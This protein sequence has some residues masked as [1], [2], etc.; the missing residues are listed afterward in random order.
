MTLIVQIV[1]GLL[2]LAGLVAIFLS[3]KNW[4]WTQLV[5][6]L[7]IFFSAIGF[8]V[9][10]AETVRIHN[11]LRARIP[12]LERDLDL[13]LREKDQLINGTARS[14]GI[15]Q[16]EHQLQMDSRERG[17]AWRGVVPTG[18]VD[19]QGRVSVEI[20]QPQPHGLDADSIVYAFE[21]GEPNAADPEAG[22]EF[23]G[24][25]R[26]TN[27][28][29]AGVTLEPVQLIDNRTG[30]RLVDS[31]GPWSLYETMPIDRHRLFAD[32][33]EEQL[34]QM[35]PEE[36][37]EEYLRHGQEA[38]PDDDEWHVIGLDENGVRVGPDDLDKAVKRLYNRTLR[39]YAFI[40]SE[41]ANE[42]VAI[43]ARQRAVTQDNEK[44]LKAIASAEE[45]GKFRQQQINN[46]NADLAAMREDLAAI[47]S[48]LSEITDL[49]A[50]FKQRVAD[51]LQANSALAAQLTE[52]Q[53][54]MAR[55]ID[56]TAP[57]PSTTSFGP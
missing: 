3:S 24:E 54:D 28:Q 52:Y 33:T 39:D 20:P 46:L 38:T 48:H 9:L 22:A 12:K 50:H 15:L 57:A 45:T 4:H 42:K 53:L 56:S 36:S 5:L 40:F 29:P 41:L 37:I 1:L 14:A 49:L 11:N 32:F 7:F 10:A 51:Y 21:S 8:L 19:D 13:A 47:E 18:E 26:V 23:L 31:Q 43:L 17:R 16:L 30:Q 34:Q 6:V 25:F 2:I 27:V 44:L 55:Y 35:L